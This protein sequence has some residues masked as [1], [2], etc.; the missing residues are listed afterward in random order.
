MPGIACRER[1][2][3]VVGL[4]RAVASGGKALTPSWVAHVPDGEQG[5]GGTSGVRQVV[6]VEFSEGLV[7]NPL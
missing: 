5:N 6:L 2:T 1:P 7:D 3:R 4:A